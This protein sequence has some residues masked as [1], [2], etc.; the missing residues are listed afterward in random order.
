[1]DF[2]KI[3]SGFTIFQ[4]CA[5]LQHL[6]GVSLRCFALLAFRTS[7]VSSPSRRI[8]PGIPGTGAHGKKNV[9]KHIWHVIL[10]YLTIL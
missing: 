5:Q 6:E 10:H 2:P 3:I 1:M 7:N 4:M 8:F 9:M